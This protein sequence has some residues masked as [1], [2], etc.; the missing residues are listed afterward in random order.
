MASC[1]S[2][3]DDDCDDDCVQVVRDTKTVQIPCTRNT[4]KHYTVKVPRR[5]TEKVPRAVTYM[6]YETRQKQVPYTVNKSERRVRLETQ[7]FQVPVTT[8]WK[9]T[10]METRERQV[11]VDYY[12]DVPETKYCTLNE[13]VAVQRTKIEYADVVKIVY[14]TQTQT[15][16]VPETKII[17]K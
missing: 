2:N 9:R 15:R 14:D 1:G 8:Y 12:V 13:R 3:Q 7:K 11:P 6:D 17:T 5:V 10:V 16:C 4:Y